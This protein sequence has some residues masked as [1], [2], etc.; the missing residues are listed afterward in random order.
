[1]L[2]KNTQASRKHHARL[3]KEKRTNKR[4]I[5]PKTSLYKASFKRC[6]RG[7]RAS[8]D[9]QSALCHH[10]WAICIVNF[11]GSHNHNHIRRFVL[12]RQKLRR[13]LAPGSLQGRFACG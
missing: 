12:S 13:S 9:W 7:W 3:A 11:N 6:K 10:S 8:G 4:K 5:K 2:S 1:M